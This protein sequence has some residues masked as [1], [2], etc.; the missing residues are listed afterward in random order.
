LRLG[1]GNVLSY[2]LDNDERFRKR[3]RA[4]LERKFRDLEFWSAP[5]AGVLLTATDDADLE[6][7]NPARSWLRG[8]QKTVKELERLQVFDRSRKSILDVPTDK[9]LYFIRELCLHLD[10]S[11]FLLTI[12]EIEKIA[13]RTLP[14][15]RGR[16]CLSVMRDLVNFLVGD[17][18]LPH[19]RGIMEGIF[20]VFAISTFF[21]GYSGIIEAENLDF[22]AQADSYGKPKTTIGEV[23]R[24]HTM[25]KHNASKVTTDVQSMAELTRI[26]ERV[27]H[28][29]A[30][31]NGTEASISDAEL[32]KEAYEKTGILKAGENVQAMIS[33]LDRMA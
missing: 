17:D 28:C 23:P 7:Q 10:H 32:A 22:R 24:L 30:C 9:L 20:I 19:Q 5:L 16:E 14:P 18:A 15:A 4:V 2:S 25:L 6:L 31:A 11:G 21:L 12:D 3:L 27:K 1:P 8:E 33:I 13:D 26:A 29:Y